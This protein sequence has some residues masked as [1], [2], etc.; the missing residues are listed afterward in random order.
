MC[1]LKTIHF[2]PASM[3][4]YLFHWKDIL[5]SDIRKEIH[6]LLQCLPNNRTGHGKREPP[7]CGDQQSQTQQTCKNKGTAMA[8]DGDRLLEE[9]P[10]LWKL[11]DR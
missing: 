9:V 5:C 11:M 3:F 7:V 10:T 2:L 8:G 4:L 1:D 6:L